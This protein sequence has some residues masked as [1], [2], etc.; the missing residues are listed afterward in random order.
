MTPVITVV[1][2]AAI[3]HEKITALSAIGTALTLVGLLLSESKLFANNPLR[4]V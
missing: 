4:P 1:T 2:S 3:L